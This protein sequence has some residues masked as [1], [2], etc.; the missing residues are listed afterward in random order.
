VEEVR[1]AGRPLTEEEYLEIV[2]AKTASLFSFCGR[3]G[4]RSAG[5][6]AEVADSLAAFG[7]SFGIAFQFADDILDLVGTDGRSGK[8]EGRDLAERKFTLPL[9]VAAEAGGRSVRGRLHRILDKP[10]ITEQ[11]VA[12]ARQLV[13]SAGAIEPAWGRVREWLGAAQR[14]LAAVPESDAKRALVASC[15]ELFPMPVMAAGR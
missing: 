15:G 10:T 2:R 7:E 6:S 12:A 4:A 1:A 5:G 9:I 3:A 8:P 14:E 11:D 13:E